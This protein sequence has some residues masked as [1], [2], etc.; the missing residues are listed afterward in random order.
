M[1]Q[2]ACSVFCLWQLLPPVPSL[3]GKEKVEWGGEV[4]GVQAPVRL[5]KPKK[6]GPW[7]EPLYPISCPD[8]TL[9]LFCKVTRWQ[10]ADH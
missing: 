2:E 3:S 4:A 8:L 1:G 5:V 7:A 10:L 6:L 9:A